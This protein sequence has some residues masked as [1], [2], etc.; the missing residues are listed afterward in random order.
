MVSL[1]DIRCK[2]SATSLPISS[3]SLSQ[4]NVFSRPNEDDCSSH[5][6]HPFP[7]RAGSNL[8]R[9]QPLRCRDRRWR[10]I[11]S[12]MDS[13]SQTSL[14]SIDEG[15]GVSEAVN[16]SEMDSDLAPH[17]GGLVI[18]AEDADGRRSYRHECRA[19]P[20]VTVHQMYDLFKHQVVC[21][22]TLCV[23]H[24]EI[25]CHRV[26]LASCSEYFRRA[27]CFSRQEEARQRISLPAVTLHSLKAIVKFAYTGRVVIT[28]ENVADILQAAAYLLVQGVRLACETFLCK[29]MTV[30][31]CAS[32]LHLSE[33]YGCLAL[34]RSAIEFC[35]TNFTHMTANGFIHE[36]PQKALK[37]VLQSDL[38]NVPREADVYRAIM[39][40]TRWGDNV[41]PSLPLDQRFP[42]IAHLP[43]L[44]S[45]LRW[46]LL[47]P[48]FVTDAADQLLIKSDAECV[49]MVNSSREHL[50][51]SPCKC[52]V[53]SNTSHHEK[54][55]GRLR[56]SYIRDIFAIGGR[57]GETTEPLRSVERYNYYTNTW[58]AVCSMEEARRHVAACTAGGLIYVAGGHDGT[59]HLRSVGVLNPSADPPATSWRPLGPMKVARRGLSLVACDQGRLYAIGK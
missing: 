12:R 48:Q 38:L 18:T 40:W 54:G 15:F 58:T 10:C 59:N 49:A 17:D 39:Q 3:A 51:H 43:S 35:A 33:Q 32:L 13:A 46:W 14:D 52:T 44:L 4:S 22:V 2:M 31:N 19:H 1:L 21:D 26:V 27:F 20:Q 42:R 36:L 6:R 41:D 29:R 5:S 50:M 25:A 53:E 23:G 34:Q 8:L 9:S 56:S 45:Q 47:P 55:V 7:A 28:L 16:V 57:G 11:G 30:S 24:D 37:C